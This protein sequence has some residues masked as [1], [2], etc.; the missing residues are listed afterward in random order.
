MKFQ[1]GNVAV[2]S[3]QYLHGDKAQ[4]AAIGGNTPVDF[5]SFQHSTWFVNV[6]TC[7]FA[8]E[9]DD[10]SFVGSKIMFKKPKKKDGE[11]SE[12]SV[13]SSNK[14]EKNRELSKTLDKERSKVKKIQNKKLLSFDEEEEE[15]DG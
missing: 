5:P 12:L 1:K 2:E 15:E 9:D 8:G 11:K 3:L 10:D 14:T 4:N 13:S 6:C 7:F